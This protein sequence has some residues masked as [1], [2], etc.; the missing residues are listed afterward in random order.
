VDQKVHKTDLVLPAVLN[1]SRAEDLTDLW[2]TVQD[3]GITEIDGGSVMT[4][5]SS[6]L[7]LLLDGLRRAKFNDLP[8][9]ILN[10]TPPLLAARRAFNLYD[11]MIF[12]NSVEDVILE[13]E[14][15]MRLGEVLIE[16]GYLTK[17]AL[18]NAVKLAEERPDTYLG[19]I[20]VEE[21]HITEEQLARALAM[22]HGLPAQRPRRH[23]V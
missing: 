12:P 10:P 11:L 20:L 4:L 5:D 3:E 19:Q 21:E 2:D 6:G 23:S 13:A 22:Q 17:E 18:E 14:L 15:G 16:F 9:T 8:V 1:R 7:A